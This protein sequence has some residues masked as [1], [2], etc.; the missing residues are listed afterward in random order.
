MNMKV[1]KILGIGT[2]IVHV[3]RIAK[4][5]GRSASF[6]D[7]FIRRILHEYEINEYSKKEEEKVKH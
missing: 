3:D 5:V 1:P 2:D 4:L 6:E 7:K